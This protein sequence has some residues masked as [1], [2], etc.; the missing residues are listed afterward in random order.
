MDSG[1]DT[2]EIVSWLKAAGRDRFWLAE[3]CGVQKR[4]VDN[5]LSSSRAIPR[6]AELIIKTLM[7][8][9]FSSPDA[10]AEVAHSVELHF[11]EKEFESI[12]D[13]ARVLKLSPVQWV[14]TEVLKVIHS[15]PYR[16]LRA[17]SSRE[18]E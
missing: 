8:S 11:S 9:K 7:A 12:C 3:S 2:K 18:G 14:E 6:K 13:I 1:L 15:E 17:L 10:I 4:T 16:V 5:W